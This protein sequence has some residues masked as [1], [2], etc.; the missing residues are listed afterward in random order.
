MIN[1][2]SADV[3][4]VCEGGGL[5]TASE[6]AHALNGGRPLIMLAVPAL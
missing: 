2:L 6:A 5:G 4:V 1:V 3:V